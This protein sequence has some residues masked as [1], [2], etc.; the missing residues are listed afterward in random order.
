MMTAA[1]ILLL[2]PNARIPPISGKKTENVNE[3]TTALHAG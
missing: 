1:M 2:F 3:E